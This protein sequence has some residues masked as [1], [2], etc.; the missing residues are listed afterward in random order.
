[1][2]CAST[3]VAMYIEAALDPNT[4]DDKRFMIKAQIHAGL[5]SLKEG[6]EHWS[7]IRWTVRMFEAIVARTGLSLTQLVTDQTSQSQLNI[8]SMIPFAETNY[9]WFDINYNSNGDLSDLL[10]DLDTAGNLGTV[11]SVDAYDW[12][13]ELLVTGTYEAAD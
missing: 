3:N 1:M 12:M 11:S 10:G 5:V 8:T 13:Q 4:T 2:T 9:D 7:S 6:S